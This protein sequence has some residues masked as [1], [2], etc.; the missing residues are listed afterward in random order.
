MQYYLPP[1]YVTG[2]P[3]STQWEPSGHYYPIQIAQ[4]GLS[5]YSKYLVDGEPEVVALLTG[6]EQ[7]LDDWQVGSKTTVRSVWD[8]ELK[9][10]VVEFQ[11]PGWFTVGAVLVWY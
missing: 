7:E 9:S 8:E 6:S 1:L 10:D 2:V 3:I 5:H 11:S 4:Y